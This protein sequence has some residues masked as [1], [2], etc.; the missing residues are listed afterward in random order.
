[1][2]VVESQYLGCIAYYAH[3]LHYGG[4][5]IERFEH[6]EKATYRNRC[7]ILMPAGKLRLSVPL[8][9]GR[10]QS[11][12][13]MKDVRIAHQHNWQKLHWHSM[14]TAYRSSPFFEYFEDK[15]YP[16]YH[17][18][19][20]DFLLDLNNELNDLLLRLMHVKIRLTST[21]A[22]HKH[23]PDGAIDLRS[24][25]LPNKLKSRFHPN[26]EC[27]PYEQVFTPTSGFVPNLSVVDL[28][29]NEG[30]NAAS[31]LRNCLKLS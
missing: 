26:F 25:I 6:F 2:P 21:A 12:T 9:R 7:Y 14:E 18:K 5:Q 30:K 24:A 27:L 1:M 4:A 10:S 23:L 19:K 22:Y 8:M 13:I 3:L 20:F 11:R 29:F 28:L 17:E 16:F 15:L 31:H